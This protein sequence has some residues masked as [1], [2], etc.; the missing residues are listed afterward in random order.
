ML[1]ATAVPARTGVSLTLICTVI[2]GCQKISDTGQALADTKYRLRTWGEQIRSCHS[3]GVAIEKSRS[4]E[5]AIGYLEDRKIINSNEARRMHDDAWG[6]S[7]HWY[8][9]PT[10]TGTIVRIASS[11]REAGATADQLMIEIE[12]PHEAS[13]EVK[14]KYS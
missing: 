10:E 3:A 14:I 5:E 11:G 2:C 8:T 6:N 4:F 9:E 1:S 12:V 7:F 13:S